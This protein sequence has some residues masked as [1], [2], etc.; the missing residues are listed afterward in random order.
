MLKFVAEKPLAYACIL[1]AFGV[2]GW[3]RRQGR[4]DAT[5]HVLGLGATVFVLY[6]GFLVLTYIGHFPG[7]MSLEA[8][9]YFRYTTQLTLLV[10]LGLA[11]A[12]REA[13]SARPA[14]W[15]R[16]RLAGGIAVV[17]ALALPIGFAKRLRFDQEPPQPLIWSL[18]ERLAPHLAPD[19]RLALLLPGDNSSTGTMLSDALRFTPPRRPG[20]D[21]REFT[22]GDP[23]E[24]AAAGYRLAF[25][26]CTDGNNL[27]L[28]SHAAA[29][30]SFGDSG[31]QVA[32]LWP[33]PDGPDKARWNQNLSG[34]PLC[35]AGTPG[36]LP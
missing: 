22:S 35:H 17:A 1:A 32:Q 26:S 23:A 20:L 10:L 8:H 12:A 31:W 27:G 30:L 19:D 7:V 4:R 3:R 34:A 5:T 29:L 15:D 25:L 9:S 16:R 13:I 6:N 36:A 18:A 28:P 14:F 33:Y 2:L 11:L 21:L 24:A